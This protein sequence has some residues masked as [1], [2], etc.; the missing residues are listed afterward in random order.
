MD[1]HRVC[2]F[3]LWLFERP[4]LPLAYNIGIRNR[5]KPTAAS[6]AALQVDTAPLAMRITSS[7]WLDLAPATE[8]EES[9][10]THIHSHAASAQREMTLAAF[11]IPRCIM[12]SR[13]TFIRQ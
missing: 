2:I 1:T 7:T 8:A 6:R 12:S 3:G 13:V 9:A 5:D 4:S 11:A 10:H